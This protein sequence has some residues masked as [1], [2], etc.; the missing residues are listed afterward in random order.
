MY[1]S[2]G[3]VEISK[4]NV[5]ALTGVNRCIVE[6]NSMKFATNDTF[7]TTQHSE[8]CWFML[9]NEVKSIKLFLLHSIPWQ[10][11][12]C[13]AEVTMNAIVSISVAI[14]SSKSLIRLVAARLSY[15]DQMVILSECHNVMNTT[16]ASPTNPTSTHATHPCQKQA[17]M[18]KANQQ[19]GAAAGALMIVLGHLRNRMTAQSLPTLML[20]G[21]TSTIGWCKFWSCRFSWNSYCAGKRLS[22][23]IALLTLKPF[24]HANAC[25][26]GKHETEGF[27]HKRRQWRPLDCSCWWCFQ[28]IFVDVGRGRYR[29]KSLPLLVLCT[30]FA[31]DVELAATLHHLAWVT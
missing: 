16:D 23:V 13:C 24:A 21:L 26:S 19:R 3:L 12:T 5:G 15:K 9:Q 30:S 14:S 8:Q 22:G 17:A 18:I 2:R 6:V 7:K 27:G 28:H 4:C 1:E 29:V 11:D 31:Y 20:T 25:I 10:R